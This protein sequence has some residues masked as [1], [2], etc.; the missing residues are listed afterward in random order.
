MNQWIN[1]GDVLNILSRIIKKRLIFGMSIVFISIGISAIMTYVVMP[2]KFSSSTRLIAEIPES[3]D[4]NLGVSNVNFNLQMIN[5]YK[6]IIT[7]S[8]TVSNETYKR[9]RNSRKFEGT[10][11]DIRK[12]IR[13]N[14]EAESQMFSIS[15]T[16]ENAYDAR[17]VA[18]MV[19]IV[20]QEQAAKVG[21][22]AKV[23]VLEEAQLNL[24]PVSPKPKA[25]LLI[26]TIVGMIL[27]GVVAF[28][29]EVSD[30]T[31]TSVNE[32]E[33]I[34]RVPIIGTINLMST[35]ELSKEPIFTNS[36]KKIPKKSRRRRKRQR[37]RV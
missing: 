30:Q 8:T 13:F 31:V 14:Q 4:G 32:V 34:F 18:N 20:F 15:A 10:A 28:I 6:D 9:L 23:S 1:V 27:A 3:G 37:E 17:E 5:T 25:V 11:T 19:A 24:E 33:S 29:L 26:G 12:M 36:D 21:T 2:L 16:A 35:E 22:I 7:K